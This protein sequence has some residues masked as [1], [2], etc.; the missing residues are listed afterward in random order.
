MIKNIEIYNFKSLKDFKINL[1]RLTVLAGSNSVG[2]SSVI[3]AI[4]LSKLTVEKLQQ[5]SQLDSDFE[6]DKKLKIPLN[7]KYNLNLGNTLEVLS[8]DVNS[9]L[10]TFKISEAGNSAAILHF[11]A[12]DNKQDV[13]NLELNNY[14]ISSDFT[15]LKNEFYYLN[16]E[17]LG[18]RLSYD[19]EQLDYDYVGFQGEYTIQILAQRKETS[20]ENFK[21]RGFKNLQDSKLISQ[22]RAWMDYIIPGFYLDI[23][24]LEGKLKKAYTSFSKSS[25]TNVGF[26]ISYV[27][28]IVVNGLI[29]KENSL[30]IVENPEAH[31]HPKGQSNIGYFLGKLVNSGLQILIETHSEHVINGL[32]RANLES[33]DFNHEDFIINFFNGFDDRNNS[34]I[35]EIILD[36]TGDLSS[37]PKDF[38]DQVQQDMLSIFKL[39]KK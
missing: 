9:N 14:N 21:T 4:L 22:V 24:E 25:P 39:Q 35:K 13:Y 32:R 28:P 19:V 1:K 2:K 18:P 20:V 3:Q 16:S 10:I 5:Y 23:A 8:R 29:S 11:D 33:D 15:S 30:F 6:L 26:G 36:K 37:F 27:L 34:L 38:F 12:R 31:L 17:R 7:G